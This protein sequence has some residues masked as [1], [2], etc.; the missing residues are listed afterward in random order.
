MLLV[1]HGIPGHGRDRWRMLLRL[2]GYASLRRTAATRQ[3]RVLAWGVPSHQASRRTG[4]MAAAAARWCRGVLA[5]PMARGEHDANAGMPCAR[6]P[7]TP[8]CHPD[9]IV[10]LAGRRRLALARGFGVSSRR[11]RSARVH[12]R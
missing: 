4:F 9:G 7:S 12:N 5:K 2:S 10:G 11:S 1:V 6:V 3:M 8:S